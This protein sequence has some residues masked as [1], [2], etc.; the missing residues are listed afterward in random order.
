MSCIS[1]LYLRHLTILR[2]TS[3]A[4]Q[5]MGRRL[6]FILEVDPGVSLGLNLSDVASLS[7]NDHSDTF[8]GYFHIQDDLLA[9]GD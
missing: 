7:S 5:A 9:A 2:Q 6:Q 4:G 3:N 8:L 1:S